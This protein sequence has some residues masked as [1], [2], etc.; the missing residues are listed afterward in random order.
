[1][2]LYLYL[3]LKEVFYVIIVRLQ[4]KVIFEIVLIMRKG[5]KIK[6]VFVQLYLFDRGYPSEEIE[7][8]PQEDLLKIKE[9]PDKENIKSE[10]Y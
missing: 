6:P 9:I 1:M 4:F 3:V 5:K 2:I 10:V 8:V 7:Y